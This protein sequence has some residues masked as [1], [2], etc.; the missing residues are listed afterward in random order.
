MKFTGIIAMSKNRVIGD[1]GKLPWHYAD[2]MKFFKQQTINGNLIMGHNTWKNMGI[3][4]LKSRITWVMMRKNE[5][6]WASL[7]DEPR[8]AMVNLFTDT[9]QLPP[10]TH[11]L[12][13]G[14][15]EIYS[16]FMPRIEEFYV[17]Y[18]QKDYE[19]DTVM[20][21]FENLFEKN[22]IEFESPELVIKKFYARK[23]P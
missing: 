18:I 22:Q 8:A 21:E 6:G 3:L 16:L 5:Y 20:P 23:I 7:I 14:G 12:V 2:D 1:K 19:G 13:A 15:L 4:A 11:Y 9:T 10:D 17:T